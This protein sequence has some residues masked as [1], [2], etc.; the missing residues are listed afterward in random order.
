MNNSVA[1]SIT[2]P[3]DA[4]SFVITPASGDESVVKGV[5]GAADSATPNLCNRAR[6]PAMMLSWDLIPSWAAW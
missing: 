5:A 1:D 4:F 3:V 6:M 2:S